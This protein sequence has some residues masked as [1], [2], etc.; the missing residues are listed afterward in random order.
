M[1]GEMYV[2]MLVCR[3][4]KKVSESKRKS[5]NMEN[6]NLIQFRVMWNPIQCNIFVSTWLSYSWRKVIFFGYLC[7][8]NFEGENKQ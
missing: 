3:M 4:H 8:V 7:G 1:R 6:F 5:L 2:Q